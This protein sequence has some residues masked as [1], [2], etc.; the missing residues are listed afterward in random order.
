MTFR[1]NALRATNDKA[2]GVG[3]TEGLCLNQ[4]G[5]WDVRTSNWQRSFRTTPVPAS[6][7]AVP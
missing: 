6:T 3:I 5:A 1:L 7:G 2:P 4:A